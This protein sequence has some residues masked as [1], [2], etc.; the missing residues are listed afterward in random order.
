M[1]IQTILGVGAAASVALTVGLVTP[2]TAATSTVAVYEDTASAQG[3]GQGFTA[4]TPS[5]DWTTG[6][7]E[8]STPGGSDKIQFGTAYS[9]SLASITELSYDAAVIQA[10]GAATLAIN[11]IADSNGSATGG[12]VTLVYEPVY[13]GGSLD[14]IQDGA[15]I[16]WAT[17]DFGTTLRTE[18]V[19][20]DALKALIP[21]ATVS[22]VLFNQGSGNAGLIS[23]GRSLT[24]NNTQ[25]VF[26]AGAPP[27]Q[28]ASAADCKK[29]GWRTSE[30]PVFTNQ[31]DCV[32]F[33]ASL[34]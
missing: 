26:V 4:G 10:G 27:V 20:F 21:E 8:F 11:L 15:A 14:A 17:R 29:S 2:A 19:T 12:F 7:I 31:G 6:G 24:L 23:L 34:R 16:W 18:R 32:S 33:F 22:A 9:G 5:L 13:N 30:L 1:K 25:Y 3:W 28:L